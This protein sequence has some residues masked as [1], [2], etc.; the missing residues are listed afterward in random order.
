M[1][2]VRHASIKSPDG[3]RALVLT[4]SA[5]KASLA[6]TDY[7]IFTQAI[8]GS[9]IADLQWGTASARQIVMRFQV[10]SG[11]TGKFSFRIG[12]S[13]ANR[14]YVSQFDIPVANTWTLIKAV[15]P[16]DTTGT[17]LTDTGVGIV[18][19]IAVGV[20]SSFVG[21]TGWQ[22]GNFFAGPGQTNGV[23]TAGSFLISDV[24][25]YLDPNNTGVPP[26]WVTPD[27]ASELAACKRYWQQV[28]LMWSG[29]QL[30]SNP[31]HASINLPIVM[32]ATPAVSGTSGGQTNFPGTVGTFA[33]GTSSQNMM[34]LYEYRAASATGAGYFMTSASLNARM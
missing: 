31:G 14:S 8:E 11:Y 20:G 12:N 21:T 27:Y 29:Y 25:L 23:A 33:F 34:Q 15:V 5:I 28:F 18:F 24:G 32:R 16:G 22:A 1:A 17:W 10:N 30:V 2:A 9:R 4:T 26:P 19:E 13:A 3:G 6:A 7:A